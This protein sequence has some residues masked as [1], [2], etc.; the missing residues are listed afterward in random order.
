M[1]RRLMILVLPAVAVAVLSGL[2]ISAHAQFDSP[3]AQQR[4][5]VEPGDVRCNEGLFLVIRSGDRAACVRESTAQRMGLEMTAVRDMRAPDVPPPQQDTGHGDGGTVPDKADAEKNGTATFAPD[6]GT[7]SDLEPPTRTNGDVPPP[8]PPPGTTN[9]D[10]PPPPPPPPPPG[11]P[12]PDVPPP[13]PPPAPTPPG[14]PNPDVPPP[15]PPPAPTPPGTPNPDVPPP[16]PPPAPT[17]PPPPPAPTPPPPPGTPNPDVPPPPP[18]PAPTREAADTSTVPI[19]P[20]GQRVPF[21][22]VT[23]FRD[24]PVRVQIMV[25]PNRT[26][27]WPIFSDKEVTDELVHK[28][29]GIL[30]DAVVREHVWEFTPNKYGS[31]GV[32]SEDTMDDFDFTAKGYRYHY[33]SN[34]G[35]YGTSNSYHVPSAL[36]FR[37]QGDGPERKLVYEGRGGSALVYRGYGSDPTGGKNHLEWIARFMDTMGFENWSVDDPYGRDPAGRGGEYEFTVFN[38]VMLDEPQDIM[39]VLDTKGPDVKLAKD[40][41]EK[42]KNTARTFEHNMTEEY[43]RNNYDEYEV[44]YEAA[45][46]QWE[47]DS[48]TLNDIRND[49]DRYKEAIFDHLKSNFFSSYGIPRMTERNDGI[50]HIDFRFGGGATRIA[51]G[52]WSSYPIP[53]PVLSG[54]DAVEAAI[55]FS[56]TDWTLAGPDCRLSVRDRSVDP[57][58]RYVHLTLVAGTPFWRVDMGQCDLSEA[59]VVILV[60]A[61]DGQTVWFSEDVYTNDHH[62]KTMQ[63][64]FTDENVWFVEDGQVVFATDWPKGYISETH[65][66]MAIP[67]R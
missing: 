53:D 17:P 66:L 34:F 45:L 16:P 10:V 27:Y 42:N 26:G 50:G 51:F 12:N 22:F 58:P 54:R 7:G 28:F 65:W 47:R 55:E 4:S 6:G 63:G 20:Y 49:Y 43:I 37:Y 56:K 61:L 29:A 30:G 60:D 24:E 64:L 25:D 52:G 46:R 18:P 59:D 19:P 62:R 3:A 21:E 1:N 40:F 9:P 41:V 33:V 32:P 48:L 2:E 67:P 5:G 57:E 38:G 14:T 23:F 15:P 35:S 13:P 36:D 39:A 11:T 31:G 44:K 8:P